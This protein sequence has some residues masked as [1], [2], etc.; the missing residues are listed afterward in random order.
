MKI[1]SISS[2][3]L[4]F[5][6][7]PGTDNVETQLPCEPNEISNTDAALKTLEKVG[8]HEKNLE[9]EAEEKKVGPLVLSNKCHALPY[10]AWTLKICVL[11]FKCK[12]MLK[13]GYISPLQKGVALKPGF[14]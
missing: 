1:P 9:L 2:Q 7:H 14:S 8:E 5:E 6:K 4:S 10:M 3:I 13:S 11:S 12:I